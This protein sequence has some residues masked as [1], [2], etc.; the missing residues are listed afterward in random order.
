MPS[1]PQELGQ[2]RLLVD[3]GFRDTE[4]L[5]ASYLLPLREGWAIVETG[6]TTVR[7][8]FLDGLRRGG[9]APEEVRHVFV[10][11]I[12]LDH[13][14]GLGALADFLPNATFHAHRLGIDH[15]VDPRR[16]AESA[17][18]A[19]GAAADP[20]WGTIVPVPADRLH[21]LDGGETFPLDHGE[22]KV[23]ATPG[24]ARH[25]VSFL[26]TGRAAM[27]TGDSAGVRLPGES[28]A[29]PAV[30]PP[31]LDL[32]ALFASLDA[33]A[34]TEPREI[35]Y[36]HFG[37]S[38]VDPETW[39]TYRRTVETWRDRVRSVALETPDIARIAAALRTEDEARLGVAPQTT[40]R[41]RRSELVGGYDLAAQGLLRYLRTRGEVPPAAP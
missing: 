25:H 41:V 20:L 21:P 18:R 23:L 30:P 1:E 36:T 22:L 37:P 14:G 12:H 10:S 34:A 5:I 19:W 8:A 17:R 29:R 24:H 15:L 9:V 39:R 3:L 28:M 11:H 2:G 33:M 4:G 26:D 40:T 35:L 13:S 38:P 27:L 6:P 32:E 16:L 31:D 7:R